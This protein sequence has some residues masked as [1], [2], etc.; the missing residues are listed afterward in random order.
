MRISDWSSDVCSSD[1]M[2][3]NDSEFH[4]RALA[5]MMRRIEGLA[6]DYADRRLSR[7]PEGFRWSPV[8]AVVQVLLT[9][10][11]LRGAA[12]A[13]DPPYEQL[14]SI[15]S[16]EMGAESDPGA[17][18]SP[19]REYLARPKGWPE[20]LRTGLA[21]MPAPPRGASRSFGLAEV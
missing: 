13:D 19:W 11:W 20:S 12:L 2:S 8:P 7:M 9:R 10:A 18:C 14:R 1:L 6:S 15:L 4:R 16:D 3:L 17:R 21:E 5:V